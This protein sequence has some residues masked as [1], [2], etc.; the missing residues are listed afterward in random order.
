MDNNKKLHESSH[1]NHVHCGHGHHH[2][3][4]DDHET[5]AEEISFEEKLVVLFQH[6]IEHNNS[7]K[8]NYILWA[9]K[10]KDENLSDIASLLMD[11]AQ[12]SDT[13][14]QKLSEALKKI[15]DAKQST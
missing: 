15:K 10:A 14:S 11:A 12:V 4:H 6:W 3:K 8:D 2:H 5:T 9:E 7:H 13:I 1:N